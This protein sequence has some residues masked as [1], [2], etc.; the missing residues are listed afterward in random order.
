MTSTETLIALLDREMAISRRVLANVPEGNAGW[1]PHPKS[2]PLGYLAVLVATMPRWIAM[3]IRQDELDLAPPDGSK[4]P[5]QEWTTRAE[6]LAFLDAAER[7]ARE[8]LAS[9]NDEY[10]ETTWNLLVGGNVVMTAP[11]RVVIEDTL[12]HLAHHRGQLT[13][14][15]RLNDAPVPSVYGP[16]ADEQQF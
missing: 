6:L 15:M 7:D 16:S 10:L 1:K 9:T 8:A 12:T 3:A 14:Y 5:G 11:R 4:Q 13:V 2:M